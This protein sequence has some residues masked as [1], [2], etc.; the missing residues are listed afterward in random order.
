MKVNPF[1]INI[2]HCCDSGT[3]DLTFRLFGGDPRSV[4]FSKVFA[5][6][7]NGL[8]TQNIRDMKGYLGARKVLTPADSEKVECVVDLW[9]VMER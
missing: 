1:F 5:E 4:I 9:N 7:R 3:Y 6:L 8:T 2:T